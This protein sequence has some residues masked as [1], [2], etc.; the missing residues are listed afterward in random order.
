MRDIIK[1]AGATEEELL[2]VDKAL[3]AC[4][5][6]KAHTR[7]FMG[8]FAINAFSGLSMYLPCNGSTELDKYYRTLLWN[9]DTELVK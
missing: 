7:S 1:E 2:E 6:Y 9:Q 4:T 8:S 3:A 5:I